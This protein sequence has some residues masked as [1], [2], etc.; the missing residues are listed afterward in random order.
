MIQF[1]D[2]TDEDTQ[3]DI[4]TGTAAFTGYGGNTISDLNNLDM[5]SITSTDRIFYDAR[6]L[7]QKLLAGFIHSERLPNQARVNPISC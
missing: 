1:G 3:G 2:G 6:R 7:N 5:D 4:T